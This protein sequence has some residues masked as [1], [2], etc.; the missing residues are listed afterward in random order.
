MAGLNQFNSDADGY[1]PDERRRYFSRR[2]FR[3]AQ[4]LK[5]VSFGAIFFM[6]D[7]IFM[8]RALQLAKRGEG[9]V[10]PNPLVGA[11]LVQDDKIISEGHHV[12]FGGPHAEVNALR[13]IAADTVP[14]ATLYV[15]L[16]PCN[17][18]GKTPPCTEAIIQSG[19]R[20]VVVGMQD[21]NPLVSGQG[22]KR[23]K[24]AGVV[25]STGVLEADCREI[26]RPF[27]KYITQKMPYVT[28]KIAQTLDGKIALLDGQSKW[29]TSEPS[30]RWVHRLRRAQDAVLVG[31]GT[32]I[33]DDP[34]LTVR[35]DKAV[36][37]RR[38]VLDSRLRIPL[39]ARILHLDE[40]QKTLIVTGSDADPKKEK[41]LLEL[42]VLI[43]RVAQDVSG[44]ID[45]HTFLKQAAE[46][47][48]ISILV[49]GGRQV[50]SAFIR[51]RLVDRMV[52]MTAPKLFGDGIS[53]FTDLGISSPDAAVT[54]RSTTLRK[55]GSDFMIDARF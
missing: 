47:G 3:I 46:S 40:P 37:P 26:N 18:H 24:A 43:W 4:A 23:L 22:I 25:V 12:F 19:I 8:R 30:R 49:E 5:E 34:Q 13:K 17:H 50:F 11:V 54:F 51:K 10:S 7:R 27:I 53:P 42:G 14:G 15:N 20:R 52:V 41:Q 9:R 16:E 44:Q 28:L 29:I 2:L 21:P 45:L 35:Y 33:A 36:Q 32:V 31:V 1:S 38:I 55:M 6:D 39:T 48:I